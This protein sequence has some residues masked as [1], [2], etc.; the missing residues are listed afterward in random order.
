MRR[1]VAVVVG[2]LVG[3]LLTVAPAEARTCPPA[4]T[5]GPTV[6]EVTVGTRT[7]PVKRV[8]FRDGGVLHPPATN[9]AAGLSAR[10]QRLSAKKG[11]SVITWHVRYGPGCEGALNSLITLPLG[12]T[13]TVG[14]VG[15]TP[16]WYT[17]VKR[18]TVPRGELKGSWFSQRGRKRLVLITCTDYVG[19]V[20]RR[21]IGITAVPIP[22][23][24]T[25][26]PSPTAT[27]PGGTT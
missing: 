23:P 12:S 13:F 11:A 19:G 15:K 10:N 6:A 18:E 22:A 20:F 9:L 1:V 4:T 2:A 24:A 25:P 3:S 21:T 7:V 17:I 8:T 16:R 26:V 5:G 14:A 27:P